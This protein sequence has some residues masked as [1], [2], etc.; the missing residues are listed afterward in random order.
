MKVR[1]ALVAVAAVAAPAAAHATIYMTLA[2]AQAAMLPGRTLH[3]AEVKLT[4]AQVAAIQ[5]DSGV[6]VLTKDV[7][8]WRADDGSWFIADEVVGKHE[9]IPYAVALDPTGAVKDVQILEYRESYGDQV[10][11]PAWR[12]QFTGKRHGAALKLDH[13]IKNISGATL[14]SKHITDGV[15][16]VLSTYALVLSQEKA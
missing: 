4:D 15:K 6:H 13:D 11:L 3:P 10:R 7:K 8:A 2:Q 1:F 5:H 14:S 16:R 9:F 12:A